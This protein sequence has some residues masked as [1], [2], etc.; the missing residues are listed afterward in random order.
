MNYFK[1]AAQSVWNVSK[2]MVTD[3]RT[4]PEKLI[5]DISSTK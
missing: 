5:D 2:A 1:S 4:V 3:T